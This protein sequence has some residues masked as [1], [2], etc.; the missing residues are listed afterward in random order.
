MKQVC[1][2]EIY[3]FLHTLTF[4]LVFKPVDDMTL[5]ALGPILH[6]LILYFLKFTNATKKINSFEA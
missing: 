2:E 6:S 3:K 1:P 4:A 5:F